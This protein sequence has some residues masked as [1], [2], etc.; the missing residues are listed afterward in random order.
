[1]NGKNKVKAF[2]FLYNYMCLSY[3]IILFS[4]IAGSLKGFVMFVVLAAIGLLLFR[5]KWD[6][7]SEKEPKKTTEKE[8][9]I[10]V[11]ISICVI[12]VFLMAQFDAYFG[13]DQ[14][15]DLW[16]KLLLFCLLISCFIIYYYT[17]YFTKK[18]LLTF[19]NPCVTRETYSR[20]G[21][22]QFQAMKRTFITGLI[23]LLILFTM[24]VT[25]SIPTDYSTTQVTHTQQKKKVEKKIKKP[26]Q[27]SAAKRVTDKKEKTNPF[28]AFLLMI[29]AKFL[30]ILF[31]V[32]F[33]LAVV[34][35]VFVVLRRLLSLRV[36]RFQ[37]VAKV[38]ELDSDGIDEYIPIR[39]KFYSNGDFSNDNNGKV[40]K[41]FFKL[42]RKNAKKRV[43]TTL[44]AQEMGREYLREDATNVV[45]IYD[46]A[47]Y[48]GKMCSDVETNQIRNYK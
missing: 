40:R 18:F 35:L 16:G 17:Q 41:A 39:S 37:R 22:N 25:V 9:H 7:V 13:N 34:L 19:A 27:K 24:A 38:I 1:M 20:I 10:E 47:R 6:H 11:L 3:L 43:D 21:H 48:S 26:K 32:L 14:V 2:V 42:I 15:V 8:C 33:I 45:A 30:K 36:P 23:L 44:T 12:S 46:K 29:L 5:F 31:L 28:I 4:M